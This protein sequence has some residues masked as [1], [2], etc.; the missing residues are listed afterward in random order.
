MLTE[1]KPQYG[2]PPISGAAQLGAPE[3]V[4]LA[5][6]KS[7]GMINQTDE[8]DTGQFAILHGILQGWEHF[9]LD[10][11]GCKRADRCRQSL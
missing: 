7:Q 11:R 1:T 9:Q 2:V 4:R 10:P 5:I 6:G 8:N 3:T